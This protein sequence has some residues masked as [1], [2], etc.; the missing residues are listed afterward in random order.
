M[1]ISN[2]CAFYSVYRIMTDTLMKKIPKIFVARAKIFG[3]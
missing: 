3:K 2:Y 1:E